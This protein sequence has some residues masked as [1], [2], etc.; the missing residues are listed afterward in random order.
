MGHVIVSAL[1]LLV[2]GVLLGTVLGGAL[3]EKLTAEL[4]RVAGAQ[5]AIQADVPALMIPLAGG[6]LA[7]GLVLTVL[8]ALLVTGANPMKRK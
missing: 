3:W 4:M 6:L 5:L 1:Y 8:T 7:V 2:P